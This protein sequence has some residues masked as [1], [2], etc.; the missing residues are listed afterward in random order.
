M[1]PVPV[2][3]TRSSLPRSR[4]IAWFQIRICPRPFKTSS[5]GSPMTAGRT[6]LTRVVKAISDDHFHATISFAFSSSPASFASTHLMSLFFLCHWSLVFVASGPSRTPYS[7]LLSQRIHS[8]STE[9]IALQFY[10]LV[11]FF[12]LAEELRYEA[13]NVPIVTALKDRQRH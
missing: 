4:W 8:I 11:R 7:S 6:N 9:I 12:F 1:G 2:T 13:S 5:P 10:F 3:L